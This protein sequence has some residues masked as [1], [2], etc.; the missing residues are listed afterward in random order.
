M[1]RQL[2]DLTKCPDCRRDMVQPVSWFEASTTHWSVRL[3]CANCDRVE[4]GS[5]D[6]ATVD[7]FDKRLDEL[8]V[9]LA[10][11][12]CGLVR[13]NMTG[14]ADRFALALADDQILPED[15]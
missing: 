4:W 6:Q 11:D 13:M 15:F 9:M 14:E 7:A 2:R 12:L 10:K 5:F 1:R 3:R 8:A